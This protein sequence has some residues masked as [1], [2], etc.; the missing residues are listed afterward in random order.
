MRAALSVLGKA[1]IGPRGRRI[2]ILGDMLELGRPG[3]NCM[4]SLRNPFVSNAIDLVFCCGPLMRSLWEALPSNL[5]GG[6]AEDSAT[7]EGKV[8][9]QSA[10]ATP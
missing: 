4:P 3:P 6:Y 2:A 8:A 5:R 7:L 1:P 10:P 9:A